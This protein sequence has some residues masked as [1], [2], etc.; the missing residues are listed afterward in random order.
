M[1]KTGVCKAG[2][3]KI[4]S[5]LHDKGHGNVGHSMRKPTSLGLRLPVFG[6]PNAIPI[7]IPQHRWPK[8]KI[9]LQFV[10]LQF[11]DCSRNTVEDAS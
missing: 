4:S 11:N 9:R 2:E 3:R 10:L 7:L 8:K 1:Q 6:W 5:Y